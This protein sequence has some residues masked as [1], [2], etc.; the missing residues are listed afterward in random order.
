MAGG[1]FDKCTHSTVINRSAFSNVCVSLQSE[2]ETYAQKLR[3]Q[4]PSLSN[5]QLQQVYGLF[6]Q[7]K[8]GDNS[9][10]KPGILSG[11]EARGKWDAWES[12]KGKTQEEAAAEYVALVKGYL[13]E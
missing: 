4:K 12:M 9:V 13:G 5:E 3:D 7:A 2:F 8:E 10:D 11:F 1:C 6:K